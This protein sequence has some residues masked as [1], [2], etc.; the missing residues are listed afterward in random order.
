[1]LDRYRHHGS[2]D[3]VSRKETARGD[4]DSIGKHIKLLSLST[5]GE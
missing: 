2:P 3:R 5:T 4:A 1:M